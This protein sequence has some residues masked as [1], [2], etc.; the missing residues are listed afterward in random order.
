MTAIPVTL[1]PTRPAEE[2]AAEITDPVMVDLDQIM[3]S[4]ACSC[5][6]GDDNPH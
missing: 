2:S 3:D 5:N 6:A 4:V 1:Y